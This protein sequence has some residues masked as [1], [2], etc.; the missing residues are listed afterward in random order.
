MKI[1]VQ[2]PLYFSVSLRN[3]RHIFKTRGK[4]SWVLFPQKRSNRVNKVRLLSSLYW[5]EITTKIMGSEYLITFT[6]LFVTGLCDFVSGLCHLTNLLLKCSVL[7]WFQGCALGKFSGRPSVTSR[8]P[9][10]TRVPWQV[11]CPAFQVGR[12]NW[13]IN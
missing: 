10:Y 13:L 11:G 12:P 7:K 9:W 1:L 6:L 4:T 3:K 5:L 2:L 8:V